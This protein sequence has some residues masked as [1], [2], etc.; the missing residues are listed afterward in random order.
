MEEQAAKVVQTVIDVAPVAAHA[1]M[2]ATVMQH[3]AS[4]AQALNNILIE[5]AIK[6]QKQTE[7]QS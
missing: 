5:Q 6:E 2:D 3:G 7:P 4:P 1:F